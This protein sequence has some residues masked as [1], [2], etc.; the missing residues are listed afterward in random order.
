MFSVGFLEIC[1]IC[2]VSFVLIGPKNLP[3]V[4]IELGKFFVQ[5]RRVT[6]EVKN[7]V[8]EAVREA[9]LEIEK[10]RDFNLKK[11]SEDL[12]AKVETFLESEVFS[13]QIEKS[14]KLENKKKVETEKL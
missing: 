1:V 6:N 2:V 11:S 9:N 14:E 3:K 13:E 8:T 4:M 5:I 7:S 10:E 12:K